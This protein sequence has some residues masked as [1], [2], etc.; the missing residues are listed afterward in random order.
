[1]PSASM[2]KI[3]YTNSSAMNK[4]ELSKLSKDELINMLLGQQ[5]G[6]DITVEPKTV[7]SVKPV[8]SLVQLAAEQLERSIKRPA[9]LPQPSTLTH[10]PTLKHLV[11][12]AIAKVK[13]NFS[14]IRPENQKRLLL[15]IRSL[16]L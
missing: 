12:N 15:M 3:I 11:A 14:K 7:I 4:S 10:V 16:F 13:I 1:M 8:K 2:N 9:I 6:T 5:T